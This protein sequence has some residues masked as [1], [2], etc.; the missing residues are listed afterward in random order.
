[1]R[2]KLLEY[3]VWV[4]LIIGWNFIFPNAKPIT[5]VIMAIILKHIF[6]IIRYF[7]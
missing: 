3:I 6:D 5:D 1:M 4:I 7:K 2:S